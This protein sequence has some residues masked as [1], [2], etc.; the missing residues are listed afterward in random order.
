MRKTAMLA[1]L[2]A[3]ALTAG[4]APQKVVGPPLTPEQV[5]AQNLRKCDWAQTTATA[6]TLA[7]AMA[8]KEIKDENLRAGLKA[9]MAGVS[10]AVSTYCGEVMY[11]TDPSV[12]K[13]ALAGLR[14]AMDALTAKVLEIPVPAEV[15]VTVSPAPGTAP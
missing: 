12:E 1:L 11:G 10:E 6:G 3:L 2:T 5:Q 9:A 14:R 4:C 15:T 7:A 13:A 8:A